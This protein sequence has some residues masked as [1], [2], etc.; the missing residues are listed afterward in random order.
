MRP[1]ILDMH[2]RFVQPPPALSEDGDL[3]YIGAGDGTITALD[4][5]LGNVVHNFTRIADGDMVL[6]RPGLSNDG[7]ALYTII[8]RQLSD[9]GA[10]P[11]SLYALKAAEPPGAAAAAADRPISST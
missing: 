2:G 1:L 10:M 8:G 11:K 7:K 6:S 4:P 9:S 3:L 5:R